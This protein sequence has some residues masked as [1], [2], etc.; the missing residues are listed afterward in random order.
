V[1][2]T[3]QQTT[4]AARE[5][6]RL[7]ALGA[8]MAVGLVGWEVARQHSHGL[9]LI[10]WEQVAGWVLLLLVAVLAARVVPGVRWAAGIAGV[11]GVA[12]TTV[13][14]YALD[15]AIR[16]GWA[17]AVGH[18]GAG[19]TS[20]LLRLV[21]AL[22]AGLVATTL[23]RASAGG[24]LLPADTVQRLA[25]VAWRVL[26]VA[27]AGI[28]GFALF[29]MVEYADQLVGAAAPTRSFFVQGVRVTL[30]DVVVSI[31][32]LALVSRPARLRL[33]DAAFLA[34][35]GL[36]GYPLYNVAMVVVRGTLPSGRFLWLTVAALVVGVALAV[37]AVR[38]K[39]RVD[40]ARLVSAD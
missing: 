20:L 38:S 34:A 30:P 39:L 3:S 27:S 17:A 18:G 10:Q 24:A 25:E 29:F 15:E 32:V 33:P 35:A 9:S 14:A 16:L 13:M 1:T 22:A 40:A 37:W 26:A 23:L 7:L 28:L 21:T 31:V 6:L 2:D 5:L 12:A 19:P 11:V 8:A 4:S 36:V